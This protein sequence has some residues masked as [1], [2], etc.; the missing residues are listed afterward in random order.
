[1]FQ[2]N[3]LWGE[4]QSWSDLLFMTYAMW[5]GIIVEKL[6]T[7]AWRLTHIIPIS[8]NEPDCLSLADK[9]I[10]W[11]HILCIP[12]KITEQFIFNEQL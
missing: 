7:T 9:L 2:I 1:M 6:G 11:K 8:K 5:A 3:S 12:S 10:Q 4:Y